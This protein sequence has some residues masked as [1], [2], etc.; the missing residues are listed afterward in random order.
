MKNYSINQQKKQKFKIC[1][2]L[3]VFFGSILL[4]Y[5]Q[6]TN[7]SIK[8]VV[9]DLS[10]EPLMGASIIVK[11]NATGFTSG[12]ISNEEGNYKIQQLP[13]GGPYTVTAQYLGYQER[14]QEGFT[15]NLSDVI[16]ID[17]V[18]QESATALDEVIV[19]SNNLSKRIQQIG[20]STK[21]GADQIKNL[22]TEG[23]N[24]TRLTSLS[25]LQGGG[26][27]NLG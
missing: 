4:S 9:K 7:A 3:M 6:A 20:A 8:G 2:I 14:F 1:I 10:G 15:L 25:P 26:D 19:S 27:I 13:L 23:R 12:S 21:I 11:N 24:F 5:G 18:L 22:P 17:F 16:T